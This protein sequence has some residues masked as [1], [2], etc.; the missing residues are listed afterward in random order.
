MKRAFYLI[1]IVLALI[2]VVTCRQK[3]ENKQPPV[4][5][6]EIKIR[7]MGHYNKVF[8][9]R[10]DI[11]LTAAR[12]NGIPEILSR[13]D[14]D[15]HK[16]TLVKIQTC[17]WYKVD[18]LTHSI[19]YLV[20]KAANLLETIGKAFQDSLKAQGV[21]SYRII[22][23]SVLRSRAD[24]KKLRRTNVNASENSAHRHG[25]TFDITYIR[26][27]RFNDD[28]PYDIPT[29]HLK[30]ILAEVL[31]DLKNEKKCYIKYEVRQG[32]FHITVR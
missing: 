8:N 3:Q 28:Y 18:S 21:D 31:R 29:E 27:N 19:P 10:N 22:V 14:A 2:C 23:T 26:F 6:K 13:E 1:F 17:Q 12:K 30:H 16:E 11:Q 5:K 24:V 4:E 25:T 15:A 7:P 9:D 20:P 32:C